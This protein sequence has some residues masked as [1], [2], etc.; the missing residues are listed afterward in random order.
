MMGVFDNERGGG[1]EFVPFLS[2]GDQNLFFMS[3]RGG[4]V[5]FTADTGG[6]EKLAITCYK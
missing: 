6:Q 5:F 3:V 1:P 4:S 2:E